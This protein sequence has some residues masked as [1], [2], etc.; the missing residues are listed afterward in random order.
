MIDR[1]AA[2]GLARRDQRI[3]II[4][5]AKEPDPGKPRHGRNDSHFGELRQR[6]NPFPDEN[7][8]RWLLRIRKQRSVTQYA[9]DSAVR[10]AIKYS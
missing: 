7:A 3:P 8:V 9:Q 6:E 2:T 1:N 4:P 5:I 10:S